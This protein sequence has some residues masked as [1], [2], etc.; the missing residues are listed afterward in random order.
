M[1]RPVPEGLS[2]RHPTAADHSRV[3]AVMDTW[4]NGFGGTAGSQQRAALLPRLYFQH[5][6]D[7][8]YLLERDGHLVAFLIGF[9]SPSQPGTAYIHFAGVEPAARRTGVAGWL[10]EHF[11]AEA[12]RHRATVVRCITSPGNTTSIAFH[13][14]MG[15][16]LEP[17]DDDVDGVPVHRDYDGPNLDRVSFLRPLGTQ[18]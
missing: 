8:S 16:E 18:R 1:P 15:F 6:A 13:T 7:T 17:G 5:F 9:L 2:V 10:Y 14:S 11:F 3:L 4:W 12:C